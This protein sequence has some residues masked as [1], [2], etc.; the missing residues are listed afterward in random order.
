MWLW[1]DKTIQYLISILFLFKHRTR[2]KL[3]PGAPYFSSR[4]AK[5]DDFHLR[6]PHWCWS[7][8]AACLKNTSEENAT[9]SENSYFDRPKLLHTWQW[10][11][12]SWR[13]QIVNQRAHPLSTRAAGAPPW[14]PW[15]THLKH[16]LLH[17]LLFH[18]TT[19]SSIQEPT[20]VSPRI[21]YYRGIHFSGTLRMITSIGTQTFLP[22]QWI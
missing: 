14:P 20:A 2:R 12:F 17:L 10:R 15:P 21:N 1:Q 3:Q 7:P 13:R 16:H 5:L 8:L 18:L 22:M 9:Q 11:Q 4:S 19:L 6:M